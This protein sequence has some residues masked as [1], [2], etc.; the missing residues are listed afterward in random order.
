M[1]LL[2]GCSER[3]AD[4]DLGTAQEAVTGSFS[5]SGT[6]TTSKGPVGGATVKL[7]GS[8]SRT[9]FSDASGHYA[10]SGLGNGAYGLS[11]SSST[12]CASNA[13]NLNTLTTNVT[14]DLGMTG[15]G[16]ASVV[17]VQGPVGPQGPA[18]P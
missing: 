3:P 7:T 9:V 15:T 8:E 16:C 12:T 13:V 18:G 10:I 5:I 4:H 14:V 6:V 2:A 11:A 1:A 17:F